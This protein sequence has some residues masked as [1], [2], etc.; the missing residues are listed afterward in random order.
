MAAKT[1]ADRG[2]VLHPI[3]LGGGTA[4]ALPK[5]RAKRELQRAQRAMARRGGGKKRPSR[6]HLRGEK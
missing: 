1:A 5:T 3:N 2:K 4:L 6:A